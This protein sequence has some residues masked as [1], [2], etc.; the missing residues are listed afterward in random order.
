RT[1]SLPLYP[2]QRERHWVEAAELRTGVSVFRPKRARLSDEERGWLHGLQW[3][4]ADAAPASKLVVPENPWL[5]FGADAAIGSELV[6]ALA[7]AG[8]S[9]NAAP[10]DKLEE[11]LARH[12]A[13]GMPPGGIILFANHSADAAFL[14]VRALQARLKAGW[15]KESQL[16]F[17]T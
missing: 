5:I 3:V 8:A 4:P 17:V 14:P 9:A 13:G 2:W 6:G 12:A 16:W 1:V 15:S 10:L 11:V 7:M